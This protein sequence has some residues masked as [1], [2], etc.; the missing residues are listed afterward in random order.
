[1]AHSLTRADLEAIRLLHPD[2]ECNIFLET[3]TYL[4]ETIEKMKGAFTTCYSI[5]LKK[6]FYENCKRKFKK[7]KN[8]KLLHGDSPLLLRE[9]ASHIKEPMV[10]YLDAHWSSGNPHI[11]ARGNKDVPLLEEL[12]S[13]QEERE[14]KDIIIIDDQTLFGTTDNDED[15]SEISIDAILKIFENKVMDCRILNDRFIMFL[16]KSEKTQP[17]QECNL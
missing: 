8:V 13:I 9:I 15:W 2:Y 16:K 3:G 7:D 17:R 12:K 11:S 6:E 1:M 14:Y 10:F 4:G 5:E